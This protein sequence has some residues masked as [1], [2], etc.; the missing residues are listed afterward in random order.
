MI[1]K[2]IVLIDGF[3]ARLSSYLINVDAV[4]PAGDSNLL[5]FGFA[6]QYLGLW[7]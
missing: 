5:P 4:Y 3:C 2:Y 7:Y 1:N 6:E